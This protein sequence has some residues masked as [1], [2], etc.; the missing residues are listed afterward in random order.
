MESRNFCDQA[1]ESRNFYDHAAEKYDADTTGAFI[2]AT[3]QRVQDLL[4]KHAP[5]PGAVLDFGCGTGIDAAA[6]AE[7]GWRVL[8]Y[9]P[10]EGM[11]D[12]LR[13]RC[14][15][16]VA[17]GRVLPVSGSLENLY[18]AL[19]GFG[20]L[21]AVVANFGVVNHLS[22]LG[23]FADLVTVRL[24][25]VQTIILGV[26]NPFYFHDLRSGWWW[27]GLRRGWKTGAIFCDASAVPTRRYFARTLAA[28]LAPA[29]RQRAAETWGPM[30]LLAFA[31]ST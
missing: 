3:R 30:R 12:R 13:D 1:A 25:G 4:S 29:F 18:A 15:A 22:D 9:D 20:D 24:P 14:A 6:F 27:R 26:Q 8:A 28:A 10:S 19:P 2:S 16:S 17:S 5:Q 21:R 31:R 7:R 11:L 23:Q